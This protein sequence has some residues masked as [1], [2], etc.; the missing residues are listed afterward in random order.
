MQK[1]VRADTMRRRDVRRVERREQKQPQSLPSRRWLCADSIFNYSWWGRLGR[2]WAEAALNGLLADTQLADDVTIAVGVRLLEVI[3][4]A[5]ALAHQHQQA[6]A[7]AM[8]LFVG[9]EVLGQLANTLA[10]DRNLPLRTASVRVVRAEL[11][12]N[13]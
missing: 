13:V 10:E 9:F 1:K 3:Q 7:R 12:N 4:K 6:T 5:A 2:M 8:V 11:G